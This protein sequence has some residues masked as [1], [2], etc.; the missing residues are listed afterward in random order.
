MRLADL[1]LGDF[2]AE[3]ASGSPAPG[4]GSAAALVGNLGAALAGM[5]AELTI[6]KK[7]YAGSEALM[8]G[9]RSEAEARRYALLELVDR[10]A[11]AFRSLRE[12]SAMPKNTDGQRWART[13]A[14]LDAK[15]RCVEAPLKVMEHSLAM[16]RQIESALG[17]FNPNAASDVGVAA[18]CLKAAA[19]GAWM[20]VLI[21]TGGAASSHA[22][23]ER[24]GSCGPCGAS[25]RI[26]AGGGGR[27][28]RRRT[29]LR[30]CRRFRLRAS[31]RSR[32]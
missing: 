20:N 14:R 3:L 17:G 32:Q 19:Q 9:V 29:R 10:D 28:S 8:R 7:A 1:S 15:R 18:L 24:G 31:L 23:G 4:G 22:H 30:A 21:N 5:V 12:A 25:G 2:G 13:G 16:L 27:R 11:E 26:G 6:G